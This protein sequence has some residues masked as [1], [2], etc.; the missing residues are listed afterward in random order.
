MSVKLNT[1]TIQTAKIPRDYGGTGRVH[2]K[3]EEYIDTTPSELVIFPTESPPLL[4]VEPKKMVVLTSY[5][6]DKSAKVTLHKILKSNGIP[7]QGTNGCCPTV[8]EG[9]STRLQSVELPCW[10]MD[11]CNPIFVL[12]TPGNYSIRVEGSSIDVVVTAM[13][14]DNQEVN[15]FGGCNCDAWRPE[16]PSIEE[17]PSPI[18][19]H[20]TEDDL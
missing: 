9:L 13:Y 20:I 12:K 19:D 4:L 10:F 11:W 16:P 1:G 5:N 3:A 15:T 14:F 7:A 2:V 18:Y 17:H 6:L 8:T